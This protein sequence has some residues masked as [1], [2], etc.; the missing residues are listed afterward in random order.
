[1]ACSSAFIQPIKNPR[2]DKQTYGMTTASA[3]RAK[4]WF[5]RSSS[6][7]IVSLSFERRR[8]VSSA[9]HVSAWPGISTKCSLKKRKHA[10][11]AT[12]VGRC[13]PSLTLT[14]VKMSSCCPG[15]GKWYPK[16]PRWYLRQYILTVTKTYDQAWR[17]ELFSR[18]AHEFHNYAERWAY[19][20][21]QMC[22]PREASL[23]DV[24][25][26]VE[27]AALLVLPH[28]CPAMLSWM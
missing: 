18:K 9:P 25:P 19:L 24:P 23:A 13:K 10:R 22:A 11:T 12:G 26:G 20:G 1:M 27:V 8:N 3:L 7:A 28:A 16:R 21:L 6:S 4:I 17:H 2:R 5:M 14:S 15:C